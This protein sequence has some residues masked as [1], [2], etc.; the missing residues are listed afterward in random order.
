MD[1]SCF[2]DK[3]RL[4]HSETSQCLSI[5]EYRHKSC[6]RTV[7]LNYSKS[8]VYLLVYFLHSRSWSARW[9]ILDCMKQKSKLCWIEFLL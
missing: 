1:L 2:A 6:I 8:F 3:L 9:N 5:S 4:S 7:N